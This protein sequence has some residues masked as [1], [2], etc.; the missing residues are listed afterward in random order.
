MNRQQTNQKEAK[1][2]ERFQ[3]ISELLKDDIDTAKMVQLKKKIAADNNLSV[4]TIERYCKAFREKGFSGLCPASKAGRTAGLPEGYDTLI[5]EAI[6]LRREVPSRSV[7]LIIYTLEA[8]GKAPPGLLKKSTVQKK[9]AEAGF[10]KKQMEK[11]R[12]DLESTSSRR[13]CKPHRMM[14]VQADI[15]YGTSL[16]I[17]ENGKKKTLYLSTLIDDHSRLILSSEWYE[18]QNEYAVTDVFRKAILKY[19]VFDE[20]YTDN[21]SV[22]IAEQLKT[23]CAKVG[24]KLRRAKPR[25]GKS[26]GKVEKFHRVVDSFLAEVRLRKPKSAAEV[27]E[28]WNKFVEEYYHQKPHD[29]IKEYYE[30][31]NC[32]VPSEGITPMQEW[33]NDTR[34]LKYIDASIVAEAFRFHAKC[35][36]TRDAKIRLNGKKYEV[37]SALIGAMVEVSYDP[38]NMTDILV[39]YK[40]YDPIKATSKPIGSFCRNDIA[41]PIAIQ[42][43]EP[44]GS[45]VLDA[46][47]KKYA[48]KQKALTDGISYSSFMNRGNEDDI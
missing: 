39:Y 21:G 44:D 5:Q 28:Y 20:A 48:Q 31:Y 43:D 2:V 14:L 10:S 36:V 27:N 47:E 11:Y 6:A 8:E 40:N 26:K 32:E 45:R 9:L 23:S 25:S 30:S 38:N 35:R 41:I 1:A 19:G 37:D 15:K 17:T 33:N 4:R 13:F 46:I 29:G 42:D 16:L 12:Q 3:M 18:S 24:I 7:P 22:Y 34:P